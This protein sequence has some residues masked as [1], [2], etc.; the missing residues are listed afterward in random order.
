M[1]A[2]EQ[3]L[4][5]PVDELVQPDRLASYRVEGLGGHPPGRPGDHRAEIGLLGQ[6][7]QVYPAAAIA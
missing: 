2:P 5:P 1:P 4:D 7:V 6:V 3:A